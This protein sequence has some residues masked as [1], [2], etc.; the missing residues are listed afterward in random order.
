[1][2]SYGYTLTTYKQP[3]T[4]IESLIEQTKAAEIKARESQ[5]KQA[6]LARKYL[7]QIVDIYGPEGAY[8]A[9]MELVLGAQKRE[10][11]AKAAQRG[12]SAGLYGIRDYGAEWESRVGTKARATLE[13]I[14]LERRAQALAGLAGFEAGIEYEPPDYSALMQAIAAG[15]Q[16]P[17]GPVMTSAWGT[18]SGLPTMGE[19]GAE[20]AQPW[21]QPGA[22][23]GVGTTPAEGTRGYGPI[24]GGAGATGIEFGEAYGPMFGQEGPTWRQYLA[25]K[26]PEIPLDTPLKGAQLSKVQKLQQQWKRQYPNAPK[27]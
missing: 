27:S 4:S 24:P 19:F 10:D 23:V 18:P 15:Q 13:D 5:L 16:I 26:A 8:G 21:E 7:Q 17:S 12:I 22:R 1:M 20:T 3:T 6:D 14:R 2:A 9:G 11:V 25:Q